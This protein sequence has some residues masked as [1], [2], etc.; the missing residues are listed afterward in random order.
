M[1][2]PPPQEAQLVSSDLRQAVADLTAATQ[3]PSSPKYTPS[4]P[5]YTP[6]STYT[7]ATVP[8]NVSS[9]VSAKV[10]VVRRPPNR[11]RTA[12]QSRR[13]TARRHRQHQN[14]RQGRKSPP[15]EEYNP[16][17]PSYNGHSVNQPS[18][19]YGGYGY[20]ASQPAS[21]QSGGYGELRRVR[22]WCKPQLFVSVIR[23]RLLCPAKESRTVTQT[24][25]GSAIAVARAKRPRPTTEWEFRRASHA[26]CCPGSLKTS[27]TPTACTHRWK[28]AKSAHIL[29]ATGPAS[30]ELAT[31]AQGP[32]STVEI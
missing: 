8:T 7:V 4:S 30:R 15:V 16:D 32:R 23:L 18:T 11:R 10:A 22:R 25:K 19:S 3:P 12:R 31:L 2:T 20:G 24:L 17:F 21:S 13:H 5:K 28:W 27:G 1:C 26:S 14:R 9:Y 29:I 6:S